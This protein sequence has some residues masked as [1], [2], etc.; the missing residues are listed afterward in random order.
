MIIMHTTHNVVIYLGHFKYFQSQKN[1]KIETL[2]HS[3]NHLSKDMQ[4]QPKFVI[5]IYYVSQ[6]YFCQYSKTCVKQPL[7]KRPKIGFQDQ[8][9]LNAGQLYCRVLQEERLAILSTF[10]ELPFIIKIFVFSILKWPFYTRFTVSPVA[11]QQTCLSL[12]IS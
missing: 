11:N 1:E 5:Q 3:K 6:N 9:L 10:I 4:N 12:L 2:F 7:S 8:L